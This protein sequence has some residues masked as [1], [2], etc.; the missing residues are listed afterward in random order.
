MP[1]PV[2]N[3]ITALGAAWSSFVSWWI[4]LITP[5]PVVK[6]PQLALVLDTDTSLHTDLSGRVA[7]R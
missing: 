3:V 5:E 6:L 2:V 4:G 1:N 7:G